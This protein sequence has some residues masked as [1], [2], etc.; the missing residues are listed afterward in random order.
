[1]ELVKQSGI[2]VSERRIK[3]LQQLYSKNPRE[4]VRQ[5]MELIIGDEILKKS[6]PTGKNH[7]KPIPENVYEGV[8]REF[9]F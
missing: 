3:S 6:S 7:W 4:L 1:M 5:L 2:I 8:E 9:L